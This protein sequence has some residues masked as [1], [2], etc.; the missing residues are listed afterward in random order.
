M[1][2]FWYIFFNLLGKPP[3][4]AVLTNNFYYRSVLKAEFVVVYSIVSFDWH[5]FGSVNNE[6]L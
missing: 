4:I 6:S 2:N 1:Q 3:S 5:I